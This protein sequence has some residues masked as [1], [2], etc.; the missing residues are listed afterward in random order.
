MF[1]TAEAKPGPIVSNILND[2]VPPQNGLKMLVW[3]VTTTAQDFVAML[4]QY[5]RG[6]RRRVG[7]RA[8]LES[9]GEGA[10]GSDRGMVQPC[11]QIFMRYLR[12]VEQVLERANCTAGRIR[13]DD[14]LPFQRGVFLRSSGLYHTGTI[15]PEKRAA[16][17]A[18][19]VVIRVGYASEGSPI[20]RHSA[21][22]KCGVLADR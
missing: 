8:E 11:D 20:C 9:A 18:D 2:P 10:I 1:F 22:Q 7:G 6:K 19:G 21:S 14:F 16:R 5:R 3:V 13:A 17:F 15:S 12:M 4:T